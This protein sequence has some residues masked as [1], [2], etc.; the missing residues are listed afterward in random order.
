MLYCCVVLVTYRRNILSGWYLNGQ[1]SPVCNLFLVLTK[2]W[3]LLDDWI[4]KKICLDRVLTFQVNVVDNPVVAWST[5]ISWLTKLSWACANCW[6]IFGALFIWI[7]KLF[8]WRIMI[9]ITVLALIFASFR[10]LLLSP[11]VHAYVSVVIEREVVF[12]LEKHGSGWSL[13]FIILC[14]CSQFG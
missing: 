7:I 13:A 4:F 11:W 5:I 10:C 1:V 14:L 6:L 3:R 12:I 9:S 8:D 2:S